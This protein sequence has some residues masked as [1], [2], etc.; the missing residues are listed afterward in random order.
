MTTISPVFRVGARHWD[1]YSLKSSP[2][3]DPSNISG[4]IS[5]LVLTDDRIVV[6]SNLTSGVWW[7][8][9]LT[10]HQQLAHYLNHVRKACDALSLSKCH[11]RINAAFI[12]KYQFI[13]IH[14][15]LFRFPFPAFYH[16]ILTMLLSRI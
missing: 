13:N 10:N 11:T 7:F 4:T 1:M 9:R 14:L 8:D 15:W 5:P 2:L 6:R 12:K 3:S 16:D